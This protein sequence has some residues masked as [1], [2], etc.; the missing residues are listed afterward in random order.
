MFDNYL[1]MQEVLRDKA[2][3][4][5]RR[6]YVPRWMVF[7][8]DNFA[9]F[10]TFLLAYLL[11]FNFET[12]DFAFKPTI[13]HAIITACVYAAFALVFRSYSGLIRHTTI[14]DIFY[15][16]L[17]T[18]F[19]MVSLLCL[20]LASRRIW[21]AEIVTI[22]FSIILIH[23]VLITML[24]FFVRII[25][26]IFYQLITSSFLQKKKVLI[27]G[28]GA[29]GIIVKRVIQSDVQ[30]GYQIAGFLDNNKKLQ[31]KK[32]NGIP[33]YNPNI[34][35]TNFL[36]KHKIETLI[37]AIK[38]ISPGEKSEIIR[39]ALDVGLEVLDTPS[40]DNWLNGQLQIRQIRKVQLKDLLGRD[41]I[42]LNLKRI[43]IGLTG[44]TIL[45][46]GA[47]GSIGSEIVRQLTR[48][49]IKKLV[50][51]DQA[52]TPIFHLENEL[53]A[54]EYPFSVHFLLADITNPEKMERIFQEFHPD[55]VFHAAAYKHVPLME[56]NPHEA[57]RVNVGGTKIITRLSVHYGVKKFVMI[58]TDKAVNPTNVMGA[59]KRLCEMIVQMKAQQAGNKT[60]FVITRFGNVLGSNGSVI[61]LF[62]KQIEEGG[63]VTVTHPEVTRYFMTIPEACQL[64]LEAGFMGKGGE[65]F[66]FDMGKPVK[67]VDLAHQM[68]RLS[69]LVPEQ[70]IKIVF[71]GL[72]PGEKLYEELLTDKENTLPTHHPKIK[73]ARDES[74]NNK[75]ML[76]RINA[77]LSN[78]YSLSKQ[79]AVEF[80]RELVPEYKSNN[81]NYNGLQNK[82][83]PVE[84]DTVIEKS[85]L[86]NPYEVLKRVISTTP[87]K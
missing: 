5:F 46:T 35:S 86:I 16:F 4:M 59:S 56:D 71:T 12:T 83:K 60:Q 85:L 55:I 63:P 24:L 62:S 87:P 11:R 31:G 47:A 49:N 57:I 7:A 80:F 70:D 75:E 6:H 68:I 82:T 23:Y 78:L 36:L 65:I 38:D 29:T 54:K 48:F 43:G 61:P 13:Q 67:I 76:L 40:V 22:P 64:V 69:G 72:R 15:V 66:V 25:I 77:L 74:F 17:S 9:V 27:F 30:G 37:F 32:L 19:S 10:L 39:S 8:L 28:A 42:K 84:I 26:K 44:R 20:S 33:V 81:D 73:I 58:S 34:L 52:E 1:K 45:V 2:I 21:G 3:A 79:D 51:A 18:S 50:L 53:R 41:P 14:I